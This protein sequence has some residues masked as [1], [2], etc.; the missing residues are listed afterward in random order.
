[1]ISLKDYNSFLSTQAKNCNALTQA[2][3]TRFKSL[4][5]IYF[6]YYF[7]SIIIPLFLKKTA[8]GNNDKIAI[9]WSRRH[10]RVID[11]HASDSYFINR[12]LDVCDIMR[13]G[14]SSRVDVF[15]LVMKTRG[16]ELH[17]MERFIYT[18]EYFCLRNIVSEHLEISIAGHFDRFTVSLT[19]LAKSEGKKITVFQH[20]ALGQIRGL[21]PLCVDKFYYLYPSSVPFIMQYFLCEDLE[22]SPVKEE[23]FSRIEHGLECP[24]SILFIG[25][26]LN[27]HFNEMILNTLVGCYER[28]QVYFL[29][30][31]RDK[32]EYNIGVIIS[33]CISNPS[34]VVTRYSTLGF[35][36]E[37]LGYK[38]IY[39]DMDNISVDFL[40][41]NNNV[42]SFSELEAKLS[43]VD[44]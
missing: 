8:A 5:F 15:R 14:L 36:Y 29:K 21:A 43:Q 11:F 20:G 31:P 41:K 24:D 12:K 18:V 6:I 1:M 3:M 34:L 30:H 23:D 22:L 4:K 26:D 25:Q 32:K 38:V 2:R 42:T 40:E 33:E 35:N 13:L 37:R 17:F 19:F 10:S 27:P 39:V 7:L 44:L 9:C 16:H 28:E